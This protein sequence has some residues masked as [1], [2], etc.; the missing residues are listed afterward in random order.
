MRR[1][2]RAVTTKERDVVREMKKERERRA[3]LSHVGWP[4]SF[5]ILMLDMVGL[6]NEGAPSIR[7]CHLV[8]FIVLRFDS[9]LACGCCC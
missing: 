2:G 7:L 3:L 6:W 4:V 5:E 9:L 1:D 8:V